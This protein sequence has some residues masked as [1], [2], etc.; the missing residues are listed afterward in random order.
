MASWIH[1][2]AD[3][4]AR[5]AW[6]EARSEGEDGMRAVI[7]V[8]R[9]R[10]ANP[11]R[12]EPTLLQVATAERQF[13]AFNPDDRNYEELLSVDLSDPEFRAAYILALKA[14][15]PGF[16]DPTGGATH[17]HTSKVSPSWSHP[18]NDEDL[19]VIARIGNHVFYKS[20]NYR[21]A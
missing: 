2:V 1:T 13:S 6:G 12:F 17:Y 14:Q 8:M 18:G 15:F 5:V 7:A 21:S 4:V 3:A 9:N 10:A 11:R 19:S 16:S 20:P